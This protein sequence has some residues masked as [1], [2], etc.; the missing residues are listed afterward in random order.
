M[1]V[2]NT[3]PTMTDKVEITRPRHRDQR[4]KHTRN[5]ADRSPGTASN[6]EQRDL[7]RLPIPATY[8]TTGVV[9]KRRN[10][11]HR[12]DQNHGG[13]GWYFWKPC[14]PD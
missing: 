13:I 5:Q 6:E 2:Q 9:G 7:H 11:I 1:L 10:Q 12:H 14:S 3:T 4:T 8:P